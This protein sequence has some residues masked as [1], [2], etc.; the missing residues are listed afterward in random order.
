MITGQ[1]LEIFGPWQVEDYDPPA[2]E[3][4]I[5]PRNAFGNVDLFKPCMLPKKC[6]HLQ[7]KSIQN[8]VVAKIA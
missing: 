1:N 8:P 5:V 7:C 3:N 6:V 2:A 4:G